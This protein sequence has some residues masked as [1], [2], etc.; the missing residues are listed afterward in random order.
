MNRNSI[1]ALTAA[2]VMA[3]SFAGCGSSDK[4]EENGSDLSFEEQTTEAPSVPQLSIE[5]AD[6]SDAESGGS[7]GYV[8]ENLS[9]TQ[10]QKDTLEGMKETCT[11]LSV[12]FGTQTPISFAD[13]DI[14]D[15]L[16]VKLSG[17]VTVLESSEGEV[18]EDQLKA[19]VIAYITKQVTDASG[20]MSFDDLKGHAAVFGQNTAVELV[21]NGWYVT[22]VQIAN[23][24]L[25]EESQKKYNDFYG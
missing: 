9:L 12:P 7:E 17:Q 5:E 15:T 25:D 6:S 1:F 14:G 18:D 21:N 8:S 10:E 22:S 13:N 23:F 24:A 4:K 11:E 19:E 20:N 2:A 3:L 16:N